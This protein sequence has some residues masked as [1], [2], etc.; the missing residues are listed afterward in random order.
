MVCD[1]CAQQGERKAKS[2]RPW[3]SRSSEPARRLGRTP[4][5]RDPW[6]ASKPRP[7][8]P[9]SGTP[10][11][12]MNE[13][14]MFF[15]QQSITAARQLPHRDCVRF[16]QGMLFFGGEHEACSGLRGLIA[17]LTEVDQQ[18][19]LIASDQLKFRE[20]LKS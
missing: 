11:E 10:E 20:L 13:R 16:L 12:V 9:L 18:L 7:D 4:Q 1:C 3:R 19:E 8:A 5:P 17:T 2:E 6:I 15:V 14:E